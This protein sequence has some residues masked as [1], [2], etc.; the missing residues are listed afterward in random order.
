M[1]TP[2]ASGPEGPRAPIEI[3]GIVAFLLEIAADW[4][5]V[6]Y[7]PDGRPGP[8]PFSPR[9]RV[10][11]L[12]A[13]PTGR[14]EGLQG[15]VDDN[16]DSLD[17]LVISLHHDASGVAHR[18]PAHSRTDLTLIAVVGD[19]NLVVRPPESTL[20]L[21][22]DRLRHYDLLLTPLPTVRDACRASMSIE[23]HA[24]ACVAKAGPP[25]RAREWAESLHSRLRGE[26]RN[27]AIPG[28]H[29]RTSRTKP[30]IAIF[31]PWP[32]KGSGIATYA[33]RLAAALKSRY[34]VDLYHEPGY[35]PENALGSGAFGSFAPRQFA[36][37]ERCLGHRGILYQMGNSFYH[38]FLYDEMGRHPGVV[39]LHDFCLSGF[40]FWRA[41]EGGDPFENLRTLVASEY[42]DRFDEFDPHLRAWTEEPGGFAEALARR[43]LA[44]NG[45]AFEAARAVVVHSSWG[46]DLAA[47]SDP[48]LAA[49]TFVIPHGASIRPLSRARR[50]ATRARFGLP[51]DALIVGCAGI[52]AHNKMNVEAVEA[53]R[54]L[55]ALD[56]KALMLFVGEDWDGGAARGRARD[57]GLRDRIRFLGRQ[58]DDDYLD[59]IGV[60]DVGISLRRPPTY[61]ETSGALLDLL[62]HG[63]PTVVNEAGS[64]S[65]YPAEVVRRVRWEV[66]G[67]EGLSRALVELA[68]DPDGRRALAESALRHVREHHGWDV[69]A[70][71]Y[72]ELIELVADQ[73]RTG[74]G[75]SGPHQADSPSVRGHAG[76]AGSSGDAA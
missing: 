6:A 46:R 22:A 70:L 50:D 69:V 45:R 54:D 65:D 9:L 68:G 61:G 16:P 59:L 7:V 1:L 74:R 34:V 63:I 21:V 60:F 3:R 43:G 56:P 51:E 71:R 2:T 14:G 72:A 4:E 11:P 26:C 32:P 66:E 8:L 39:T 36:R 38:G 30:R 53:F 12:P 47:R 19:E 48:S 75:S 33:S 52:L 18:P 37:R 58:A 35:V 42:P 17:A 55:A 10:V 13:D 76:R 67:I 28:P 64:T 44:V 15:I 57:L 40:Q 25:P 29:P 5:F 27:G 31:S 41:H 49:R 24:V 73:D 23:P 20:D 62:R